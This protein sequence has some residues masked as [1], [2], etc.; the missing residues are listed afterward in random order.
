MLRLDVLGGVLQWDPSGSG[1]PV[2]EQ[3]GTWNEGSKFVNF[4]TAPDC[5]TRGWS[6]TAFPTFGVNIGG[7]VAGGGDVINLGENI[8]VGGALTFGP[9]FN[10]FPYTIGNSGFSLTLGG[11]IEM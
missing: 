9:I 2:N 5:R 10:G 7:N 11:G 8:T 1:L 3:G 4:A 6:N